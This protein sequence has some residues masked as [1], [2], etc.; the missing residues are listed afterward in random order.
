M[1]SVAKDQG[2]LSQMFSDDF[3]TCMFSCFLSQE[4][5]K[6]VHQA[7]KDPSWIEAMQEE[8]LQFKMHKVWILVD[9]PYGK[10]AIGTNWVFKN[11]KDERGIVVRNKARLVA[12]GHTQEEG[13]NHDKYVAEIL[14]K[15]GLTD[16]KSASTPIDIEKPFLKDPDGEDVDVHTY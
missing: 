5:P 14:R 7:L 1:T 11:K 3:Y 2:V 10:R 4:E 12:Q 16:T 8:L 6:R 9:F 15:F 13:I